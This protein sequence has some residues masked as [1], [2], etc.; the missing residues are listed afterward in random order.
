MA[1][2]RGPRARVAAAGRA[3]VG[4]AREQAQREA[5]NAVTLLRAE[6]N[7][8]RSVD[9]QALESAALA[10]AAELGNATHEGYQL[11]WK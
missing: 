5:A 10:H 4:A 11:P 9:T 2:R 1:A 3:A 7:Q 8:Q 6:A